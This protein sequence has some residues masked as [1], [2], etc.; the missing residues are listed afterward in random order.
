MKLTPG[1]KVYLFVG[2]ELVQVFYLVVIEQLQIAVNFLIH[3]DEFLLI[4]KA[5]GR[6]IIY[7]S[8][9]KMISLTE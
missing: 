4:K 2:G 5:K 3:Q 6:L 7:T 8:S 9:I 1:K